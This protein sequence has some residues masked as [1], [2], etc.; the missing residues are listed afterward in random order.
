M[1]FYPVNPS[2]VSSIGKICTRFPYL[3]SG[4]DW[5]ETMSERRTRKLFLTTR[6]MRIFS[7]GHVSS[8]KT[9]QTVSL[10]R[11]PFKSTVSPRKSCN[12]SIFVCERQT[13]E[14]SSLVASSTNKRLGFGFCFKIAVAKSSLTNEKWRQRI[15]WNC[16]YW[17]IQL[18]S[19]IFHIRLTLLSLPC[20]YLFDWT[21][22][23][24]LI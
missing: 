5:M 6:F 18:N 14:L 23:V 2:T 16:R 21:V 19:S 22:I 10:R 1:Q 13:M 7:L 20:C 24:N 3:T 12:S 15:L 11:L 4:H 17:E 9:M 8:D